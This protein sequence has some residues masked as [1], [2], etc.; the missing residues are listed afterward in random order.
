MAEES[1]FSTIAPSLTS[2]IPWV[3]ILCAPLC[4]AL[5]ELDAEP[6]A[7]E[8]N[9]DEFIARLQKDNLF[10]I[11]LDTQHRWFR[12]HHLFQQLL[13][14]Q[15]NRL[16]R[17]EEIAALHSRANGWFAENDIIDD[18]KKHTPAAFR[19]DEH[20]TVPDA[21]DHESPSPSLPTAQPPSPPSYQPL[22]D[23]LSNRELDVLDLLAQRLSNKEIAEKLFISTTTVKKHLQ[24][25]YEKL[26]VGKRR[27]AVEKA[28]KMGIL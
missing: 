6:G 12:Y 17:P 4:E 16:W 22:V 5:H 11:A 3:I 27:E 25:I 9:G 26:N 10:L 18:A 24:H 8:M 15:L 13:Q 23:P 28:M 20:R 21:T 7:G 2:Q 14:D 19:D 1:P